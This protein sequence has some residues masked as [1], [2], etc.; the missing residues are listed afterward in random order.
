MSPTGQPQ[1]LIPGVIDWI[2]EAANEANCQENQR[3]H[4]KGDECCDDSERDRILV[5]SFP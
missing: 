1:P 4:R 5:F 2:H 3:H